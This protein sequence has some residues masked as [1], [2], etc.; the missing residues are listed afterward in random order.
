ML[1]PLKLQAAV[2]KVTFLQVIWGENLFFIMG[3]PSN[4]MAVHDTLLLEVG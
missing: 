4:L 1:Q 2:R 3:V